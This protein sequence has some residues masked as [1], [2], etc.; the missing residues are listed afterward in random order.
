MR[1]IK[2]VRWY[3]TISENQYIVTG[4]DKVC[5]SWEVLYRQPDSYENRIDINC[6]FGPELP[7]IGDKIEMW[8]PEKDEMQYGGWIFTNGHTDLTTMEIDEDLLESF[9]FDRRTFPR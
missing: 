3:E 5:G 9:E 7:K 8:V 6:L 1:K 4:Y 2:L